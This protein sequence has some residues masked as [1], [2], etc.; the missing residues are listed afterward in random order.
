MGMKQPNYDTATRE[1]ILEWAKYQD[2]IL[3]GPNDL[4]KMLAFTCSII[5]EDLEN[6]IA[7][8][9]EDLKILSNNKDDKI[10]ERITILT[11]LK[12]EFSSLSLLP[13]EEEKAI[14]AKVAKLKLGDNAFE[15]LMTQAR[16]KNGA[17][18]TKN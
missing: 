6:I 12:N 5:A 3:D 17:T 7:D 10:F 15:V 14:K 18:G 2:K 13:L 9:H 16:E 4:Q 8:K 11:K 1:E